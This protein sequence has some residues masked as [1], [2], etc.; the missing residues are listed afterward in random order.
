M[1]LKMGFEF[2]K[3]VLHKLFLY[4]LQ[5]RINLKFLYSLSR[6]FKIKE[7]KVIFPLVRDYFYYLDLKFISFA[8]FQYEK[9]RNN[10]GLLVTGNNGFRWIPINGTRTCLGCSHI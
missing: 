2:F 6:I 4:Y 9:K 1:V 10:N 7:C 8:A 5:L 3:I